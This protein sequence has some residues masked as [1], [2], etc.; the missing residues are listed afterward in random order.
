[1]TGYFYWVRHRWKK[2]NGL[3]AG[4][5]NSIGY[6]IIYLE[7]GHHYAHRLA[8]LYM[9]GYLPTEIDHVNRN[10]DDNRIK[11]IRVCSRSE[12]LMNSPDRKRKHNFPRGVYKNHNQ[13]ETKIQ[14]NGKTHHLGFFATASEASKVYQEARKKFYGE[15]A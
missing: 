4:T 5:I 6:I 9:Y 1:V 14:R 3:K 7:G 12:N 2:R 13:Y 10:K 15:F 8:W 11:N